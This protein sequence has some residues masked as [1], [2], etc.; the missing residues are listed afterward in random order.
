[1]KTLKLYT[2]FFSFLFMFGATAQQEL[3]AGASTTW[4]SQ[5][6]TTIQYREYGFVSS[7]NKVQY[8]VLNP[9]NKFQF[10]VSPAGYTVKNLRKDNTESPWETSF[11]IVGAGRKNAIKKST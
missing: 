2:T 5:A 6:I 1:M 4:Y 9:N 10:T 11:V 8:T 7:G 3:P